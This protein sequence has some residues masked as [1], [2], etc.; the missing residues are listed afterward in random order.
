MK[1]FREYEAMAKLDLS[2]QE[3]E[4]LSERAEKLIEEFSAL[5]KIDTS[6]TEPLVT[7]L[8]LRNILREDTVKMIITREEL[9]SNAPEQYDGCFQVPKTLE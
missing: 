8:D 6:N 4:W 7:V 3:R 1:D 5:E 9:L 2:E